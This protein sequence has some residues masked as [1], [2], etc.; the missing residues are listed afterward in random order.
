MIIFILNYMSKLSVTKQF[1]FC[2]YTTPPSSWKTVLR[3]C[4]AFWLPYTS[5]QSKKCNPGDGKQHP[6]TPI[7]KKGNRSY[8]GNYSSVSLT[9][10]CCKIWEHIIVSQTICHQ[11]T[12]FRVSS[13]CCSNCLLPVV[14]SASAFSE[15]LSSFS[16]MWPSY[17]HWQTSAPGCWSTVSVWWGTLHGGGYPKWIEVAGRL[18]GGNFFMASIRKDLKYSQMSSTKSWLLESL[19]ERCLMYHSGSVLWRLNSSASMSMALGNFSWTIA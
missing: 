19:Q 5:R 10:I 12:H 1:W 15:V 17:G 2:K 13:C 8:P 11:S 4:A 3:N 16:D 7:F 14:G 18:R 6:V 9:S